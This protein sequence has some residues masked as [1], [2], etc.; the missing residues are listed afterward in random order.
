MCNTESL[1][2]LLA[3]ACNS[4]AQE[5]SARAWGGSKQELMALIS[6]SPLKAVIDMLQ[7]CNTEASSIRAMG[8]RGQQ[9]ISRTRVPKV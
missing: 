1:A 7:G 2:A 6:V 9:M 5:A 4:F 3:A 8:L